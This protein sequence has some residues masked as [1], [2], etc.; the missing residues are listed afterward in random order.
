ML[1][2]NRE[3][4]YKNEFINEESEEYICTSTNILEKD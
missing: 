1:V 4:K 3:N 2:L